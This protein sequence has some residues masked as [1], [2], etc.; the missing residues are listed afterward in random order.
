MPRY[1]LM[2]EYDGTPFQGW[3][4]QSE[5]QPSVQ[6]AIEA[7]LAHLHPGPHVVAGA[8]RTDTGVHATGQVA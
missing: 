7:A 8:G 2:I 4:R 6:G 1:A 5:A 3:Q